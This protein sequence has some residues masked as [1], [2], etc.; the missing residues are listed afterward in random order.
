MKIKFS[1]KKNSKGIIGDSILN[2]IASMLLTFSTQIIVY[3]FLANNYSNSEYGLILTI[4]GIINAIGVSIGNSLNNTRLLIQDEYDRKNKT[5]D[6]NLIYLF[7]SILGLIVYL[8]IAKMIIDFS[9]I[10]LIGSGLVIILISFRAYFS[11]D[12]RLKINYKKIVFSN[13]CGALGYLVGIGLFL[14]TKNWIDIFIIGEL[15]S[16]I[17][18]YKN[19]NLVHEKFIKTNLFN[20]AIQKYNY[21][22]FASVLSNVMLYLD[23]FLIFPILGSSLVSVYT[24]AS[25]LGKSTGILMNPIS[26]VLLSYYAKEDQISL[27]SFY[28]R[29]LIF[30]SASGL[31]YIGTLIFGDYIIAILYPSLSDQ[32]NQY[33]NIANLSAIILII[34]NLVQPILLRYSHS[35]WQLITQILYLTVYLFSTYIGMKTGGLL[36]FCYGILIANF[37]RFIF[38]VIIVSLSLKD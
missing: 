14:I 38:M 21:I 29:I 27:K 11:V 33:S 34:G 37:S 6:F 13:F 35:R 19:S 24:V 10:E 4:M 9:V 17:F 25:F 36:G 5:G 28:K 7:T 16:S 23:R 1:I 8:I 26:G 22:F 18:I 2:I 3:P 20:K 30:I 12:F 32:A 31:V 15:F